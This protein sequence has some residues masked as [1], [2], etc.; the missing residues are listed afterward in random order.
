MTDDANSSCLY[1]QLLS[2]NLSDPEA[3]V[4]F[5]ATLANENAWTLGYATQVCREYRR[6]L[7]LTQCAGQPMCP[8]ADADQAWHLHLTQTRSYQKMCGDVL[9][10]FLHH[11]KS[12]EGLQELRK[13]QAMYKATLLA[14][15]ATFKEP[16]PAA[17]WPKVEQ[18]FG[19]PQSGEREA[20]WQIPL[21]MRGAAVSW[22][23]LVL[24]AALLGGGLNL[25][26]TTSIWPGVEGSG[27]AIAYLIALA[28]TVGTFYSRRKLRRADGL[29]APV[30]DPYEVAWL[31]GGQ[32]R[33]IGTALAS[34]VDRGILAMTVQKQGG[35][36]TGGTCHRTKIEHHHVQLHDVER[37]C[38]AA[39]PEGNVDMDQIRR[40]ASDRFQAIARRL[41][42]A[43][44][45]HR[46]GHLARERAVAGGMLATLLALGFS[47]FW[48]G[49]TLGHPLSFL[50][51]LLIVTAI[52]ASRMFA[53]TGVPTL[54]GLRALENLANNNTPKRDAQDEP[55]GDRGQTAVA[56]T[57][58]LVTLAFALFGTQ[59][60]MA[61]DHFAGINYLFGSGNGNVTGDSKSVAGCGGGC[62][63]GCGGCGGCGG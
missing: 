25:A 23:G 10:R 49:F 61:M 17:I 41:E 45:L 5:E 48:F 14:Y 26:L 58:T 63:G 32:E 60:V 27:F 44:L 39:I 18:R 13:H 22:L 2:Y 38:L 42:R 46:P 30:L 15:G 59:A 6:F 62:A 21:F 16:P 7:Y 55:Q 34:L 28:L 33:V 51:V 11:D 50:A 52:F 1:G 31:A 3:E 8:S 9:G 4:S 35:K 24:T 54:G 12:K 29:Y 43:G 47:R 36:I 57:G 19:Q 20:S 37:A 40:V 56:A 53:A